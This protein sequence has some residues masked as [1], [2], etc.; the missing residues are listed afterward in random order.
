MLR[1]ISNFFFFNEVANLKSIL[2]MLERLSGFPYPSL[3]EFG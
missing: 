3:S 1:K 2:N